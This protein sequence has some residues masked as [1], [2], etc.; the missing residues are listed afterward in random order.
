MPQ[1]SRCIA[2][3]SEDVSMFWKLS[4]S[5]QRTKMP[6]AS[7]KSLWRCFGYMALIGILMWLGSFVVWTLIDTLGVSRETWEFWWGKIPLV[8][9]CLGV[10]LGACIPFPRSSGPCL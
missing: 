10:V 4:A 3:G 9:L 8:G 5:Q 1:P 6:R 7:V 2:H